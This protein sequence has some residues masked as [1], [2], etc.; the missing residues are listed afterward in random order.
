MKKK[1][2]KVIPLFK[3][4]SLKSVRTRVKKAK[5]KSIGGQMELLSAILFEFVNGSNLN[6][7]DISL[8]LVD[9]L[10]TGISSGVYNQY[11]LQ[12]ELLDAIEKWCQIQDED[13]AS[14]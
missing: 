5:K 12:H 8:V 10:A 14:S 13:D 4:I 6:P 11:S 2:A 9:F 1:I 3:E 7:R